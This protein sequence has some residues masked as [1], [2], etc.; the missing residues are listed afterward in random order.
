MIESFARAAFMFLNVSLGVLAVVWAGPTSASD[1][2]LLMFDQPGCY[3]CQKWDA[4]IGPVYPVTTES[5]QAPL[6][7]LGLREDLPE[8]I[9]LARPAALTPTFVL[10]AD[11]REV[12]RIE[13]YPGE[14]FFWF[15]LGELID[16]AKTQGS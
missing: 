3:Y 5:E 1:L 14:D 15:L 13:G 12:G 16:G 10:L 6:T 9:T 4:E 8:G 7:R 2:R 11:G